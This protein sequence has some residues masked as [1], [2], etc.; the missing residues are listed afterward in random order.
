MLVYHLLGFYFLISSVCL[1]NNILVSNLTCY[2]FSVKLHYFDLRNFPRDGSY[3]IIESEGKFI[4]NVTHLV[5]DH[6]SVLF[7]L[8]TPPSETV[9]TDDRFFGIQ[10]KLNDKNKVHF[11]H[12]NSGLYLA[13]KGGFTRTVAE[14]LYAPGEPPERATFVPL[15]CE[16]S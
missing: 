12:L 11:E 4:Q 13:T 1:R 5:T 2:F 3:I 15:D 7:R 10:S 8:G 9:F 14:L 6:Y 16:R